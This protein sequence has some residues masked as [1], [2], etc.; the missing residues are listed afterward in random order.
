MNYELAISP[1]HQLEA[2]WFT[3]VT[4]NVTIVFPHRW[5]G[6]REN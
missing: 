3:S 2:I 6:L 4:I 5:T 1:A